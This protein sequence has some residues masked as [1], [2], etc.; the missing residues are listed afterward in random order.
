[1]NLF[2]I[3]DIMFRPFHIQVIINFN[4]MFLMSYIVEVQTETELQADVAHPSIALYGVGY[5]PEEWTLGIG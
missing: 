2:S 1:M 4:P 5:E 3:A